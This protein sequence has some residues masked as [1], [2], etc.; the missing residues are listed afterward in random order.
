MPLGPWE[1]GIILLIVI[2]IFGVGKLPQI[3]GALGQGI[4]EFRTGASDPDGEK[5][6]Q[7][8]EHTVVKEI[9]RPRERVGAVENERVTERVIVKDDEEK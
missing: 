6:R 9:D 1:L 3:G 2:I 5:A 8:E 7:E 4:R